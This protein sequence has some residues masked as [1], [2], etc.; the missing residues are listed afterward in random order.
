MTMTINQ[1]AIQRQK[2]NLTTAPD[3]NV[4]ACKIDSAQVGTLTYGDAVVITGTAAG[5]TTVSKAALASDD[6]FGFVVY[7]IRKTTFSAGEYVNIAFNDAVMFMEASAAILSGAPVQFDPSTAKIATQ[8][9]GNTTVGIA[10]QKASADGDLIPVLIKTP[11]VAPNISTSFTPGLVTASDL[12][13]VDANKDIAIFR[14]LSAVNLKAGASGTVGTVT[15][16]PTT[17]SKGSLVVTCA[18]QTGNTAVTLNAN[19]MGQATAINIPDPGAASA[20][21][22]MTTAAL[23]LAEADVL[24]GATAGTQVAEKAVIAD[25]NVNTGIS[26][27]TELHIGASGAEV[28]V[29]ATPAELNYNDIAVLGTGAASKAVVLDA[30]EDYTWPATGVLTYGILKDPAATVIGATG[31]EINL[32]D[33]SEQ[34][35]TIDSGDAASVVKRITKIDNTVS[36]AG[37]ITLDVPNAAMLGQVKVIE[38]TV[39]GGDVTLALTNV[40]GCPAGTTTTATFANVGESL[41]VVAGVATWIYIGASATLS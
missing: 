23:S 10:I 39:D 8:A 41:V 24:Q 34:T 35:E 15:V 21:V 7:S 36:G 29:T 16:Y 12:V 40:S 22:V 20:Y 9:S 37:A 11:N 28:Q 18:D 26:K 32:L 14:N 3:W 38:M 1:F 5:Q 6:I 4:L 17:A 25:A 31:A 19:E 2:G 33:L 30:G 27:V 13:A